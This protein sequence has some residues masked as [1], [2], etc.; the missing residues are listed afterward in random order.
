[1]WCC[2]CGTWPGRPRSTNSW[3]SPRSPSSAGP[4]RS[5][6]RQERTITTW[7][8]RPWET[9]HPAR[10]RVRSVSTT[11]P[12]GIPPT[13]TSAPRSEGWPAPAWISSGRAITVSHTV[14]MS[15]IPTGSS[16]SCT[17]MFR[18]GRSRGSTWR[19][20]VPGIPGREDGEAGAWFEA[21]PHPHGHRCLALHHHVLLLDELAAQAGGDQVVGMLAAVQ[22]PQKPLEPQLARIDSLTDLSAAEGD[23]LEPGGPVGDPH[24][25]RRRLSLS[26]PK[27]PQH[28]LEGDHGPALRLQDRPVPE[29]PLERARRSDP[30]DVGEQL[31]IRDLSA[32]LD[33][34]E[35]DLLRPVE[36]QL[37]Q[38]VLEAIGGLE[39]MLGR[40]HVGV[41]D[42]E[43]RYAVLAQ[44]LDRV[45]QAECALP[46]VVE[47]EHQVL[48]HVLVGD[49]RTPEG[50]LVEDVR[51]S[52]PR[53]T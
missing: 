43:R 5:S 23:P 22:D 40:E 15:A 11:W 20:S 42:G 16:S 14:C 39:G 17:R 3:G 35:R 28:D 45:G 2:E 50:L 26:A 32:R 6:P 34:R 13:T 10:R 33:A 53:P 30:H 1:M 48:E 4:W 31:L 12:S 37:E 19:R 49:Q 41:V 8:S 18:T 7:R 52:G 47:H 36:R 44:P 9:G 29:G 38:R 21:S 51:L 46:E 25:K 24:P 27:G